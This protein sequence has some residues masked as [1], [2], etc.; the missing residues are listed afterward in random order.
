MN[1][2][3]A[4]VE[5]VL[6][7][8]SAAQAFGLRVKV[9]AVIAVLLQE[10]ESLD[11]VAAPKAAPAPKAEAPKAEAPAITLERRLD[12]LA[13]QAIGLH[14]VA[15]AAIAIGRIGRIGEIFRV[16]TRSHGIHGIFHFVIDPGNRGGKHSGT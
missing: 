6:A 14:R 9:N 11:A 16:K 4:K 7:G 1:G 3:G 13:R 5:R 2:V 15:V 12:H 8:I 10:G